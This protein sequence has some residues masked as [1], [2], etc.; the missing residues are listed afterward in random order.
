M[1]G[2]TLL[3]GEFQPQTKCRPSMPGDGRFRP[4]SMT[5]Y[6]GR[7]GSVATRTE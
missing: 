7:V 4:E 5:Q 2:C 1:Q 6:H 3:I